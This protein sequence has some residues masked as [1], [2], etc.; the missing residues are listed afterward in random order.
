MKKH[1]SNDAVIIRKKIA[2]QLSLFDD[3]QDL[4][5]SEIKYLDTKKLKKEKRNEQKFRWF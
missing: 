3:E 5:S 1:I 4:Y 2:S